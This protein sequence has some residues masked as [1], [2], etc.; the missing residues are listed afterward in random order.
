MTD[1]RIRDILIVGGGTAGWMAA[2]TLARLL[3]KGQAKVR[4]MAARL[5]RT[6]G[7]KKMLQR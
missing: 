2:S 3:P 5:D 1:S 7:G 4:L 6:P